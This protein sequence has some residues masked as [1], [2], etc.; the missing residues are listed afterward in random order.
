MPMRTKEEQRRY[1]REWLRRRRA[2]W[3]DSQGGRCVKCGS[4]DDLEIDHVDRATKS[5]NVQQLWSRAKH[6]RDAELAKCQVLCYDCHK[7]K[8]LLEIPEWKPKSPHGTHN[9]YANGCRCSDCRV[10]HNASTTEW[11][12]KQKLGG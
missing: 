3:I 9:R 8:T 11:K 6:I 10:A 12:R 7:A 1:Q 2:D 5:Y 4:P